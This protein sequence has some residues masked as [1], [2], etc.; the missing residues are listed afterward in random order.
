M[1]QCYTGKYI[2]IYIYLYIYTY[3]YIGKAHSACLHQC[4]FWVPVAYGYTI[5]Q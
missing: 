2:F 3:T 4:A 1:S 5:N